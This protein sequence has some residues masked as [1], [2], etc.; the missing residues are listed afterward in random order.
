ML[1]WRTGMRYV[2]MLHCRYGLMD[3]VT[4]KGSGIDLL[5]R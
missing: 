2:R 3:G 4:F 5:F 1:T